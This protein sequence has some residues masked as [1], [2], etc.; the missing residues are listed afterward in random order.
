MEDYFQSHTFSMILTWLFSIPVILCLIVPVLGLLFSK[1]EGIP[2]FLMVWLVICCLLFSPLRYILLQLFIATAYPFQSFRALLTTIVLIGYI[3]IVFGIMCV[4]GLG[5]PILCVSVIV[6][7]FKDIASKIR[8]W[9]AA[10]AAPIIFLIAS[11]LFFLV[12]PYAAYSTH[13]LYTKDVIR[14]TN[15]PPEYFYRYVVEPMALKIRFPMYVKEIG[16][17]NLSPEERLRSHVAMVYLGEKQ[18]TFFVYKSFPEE[19]KRK[20]GYSEQ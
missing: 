13:W 19:F 2:R 15:G 1:F 18:F 12:L 4:I 5:L 6:C 8:L 7:F 3:P 9:L 11:Y 14:A 20:T 10:L 16:F 17:D